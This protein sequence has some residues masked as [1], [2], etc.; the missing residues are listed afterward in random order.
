[1]P[2]TQPVPA[3]A[4]APAAVPTQ[5]RARRSRALQ[6]VPAQP[7]FPAELDVEPGQAFHDWTPWSSAMAANA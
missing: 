4:G 3:P 7:V 1:M 2:T 5:R 6:P